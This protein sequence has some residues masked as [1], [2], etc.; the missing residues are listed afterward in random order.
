MCRRRW[1]AWRATAARRP[2]LAQA[3][4]KLSRMNEEAR[5]VAAPAETALEQAYALAEEA[6]QE[7]IPCRRGWTPTP[8]P[9]TAREE[10]LLALRAL[11]RK[12]GVLPDALPKLRDEYLA[13]QEALVSGGNQIEK[14]AAQS[15]R[16]P[17]CL[18]DGGAQT[19]QVA[20]R[21]GEE[22]GKPPWRAS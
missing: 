8:T 21:C 17:Y 9:W 2:A 16:S 3:M 10:R 15:R 19:V 14:A 6:R 4:K 20:R 12:Y 18:S 22:A 11:A 1:K 7:L 5:K 13:K